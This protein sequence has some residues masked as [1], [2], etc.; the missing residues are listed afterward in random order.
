M[1]SHVCCSDEKKKSDLD[2]FIELGE[3]EEIEGFELESVEVADTESEEL[4]FATETGTARSNAKSKFDTEF[5][6]VRYRYAGNPN[7]EREFCK[8]MMQAN[9]V[10]RRE[11]IDAMGER[12]VNPG[13]GM[14]P[15]PNKPYSIWKYKGGGLLSASHV[16][17]T[18][19]HY[20]EKLTYRQ[21]DVKID[22]K[23][24]IAQDNA[25]IDKAN[26][27]AGQTPHSR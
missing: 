10:Y 21:K 11:D 25:K 20:W 2:L 22:V 23:S 17:G 4:Q 19:K 14:H 16:G 27:I 15:T 13:F 7:P 1:S 3:S 8:R 12:N 24:P 5:T 9:K 18:C 6:L 26:G